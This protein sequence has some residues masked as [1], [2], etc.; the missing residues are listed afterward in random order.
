M[1]TDDTVT[2]IILQRLQSIEDKLD[3][4]QTAGCSKASSHERT[5]DNVARL[6]DRVGELERAQAEGRG[7]LAVLVAILTAA[8]GLF[9][10]WIGRHMPA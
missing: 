5:E 8:V 3:S 6:F 4:M 1:S 2:S 7:K 9:F 10:E